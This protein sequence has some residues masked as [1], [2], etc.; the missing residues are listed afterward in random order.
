MRIA[1][2]AAPNTGPAIAE[3]EVFQRMALAAAKLGWTCCRTR[4]TREIEEFAPDVVLA[5]HFLVPKLTAYPTL[6]LMWNPPAYWKDHENLIKNVVSYDG[7]LFADP[8]TKEFVRDLISPLAVRFVEGRWFPTCHATSLSH[9]PRSGLAYLQTGWD[10]ERYRT[11]LPRLEQSVELHRYGP[12]TKMLPFDGSSVLD[13]LAGHAAALC[14][15]SER[16]R[17]AGVP[18]ARVFEAAAS[19]AII[20][21]DGNNFVSRT[22]GDAAL[23]VDP[24]AP[25][26][27]IV[28]QVARHLAWIENNPSEAAHMRRKAH[29]FFTEEFTFE[30]LLQQLPALVAE[31]KD[32]WRPP[33]AEEE[34]SV[35]FIVRT[36]GRELTFLDRA[37]ASLERQT[38]PR[39]DAI[40][41]AYRNADAVRQHLQSKPTGRLSVRVVEC[42][43]KGLRS[44]ALWAGLETVTSAFYGVLDDDDTLF[45]NHVAACLATLSDNP[46]IDL[47]YAGTMAVHEGG[48]VSEVRSIMSFCHF[49]A[50]VF[51]QRNDI[52]SNAWLARGSTL[53]RVGLDPQLDVGEDYYLLLRLCRGA[54]FA[55]TWRLTSEYR[56]RA[57]DATHSPLAAKLAD[58]QERIRRRLYLSVHAPFLMPGDTDVLNILI[59][60]DFIT[61]RIVR[62]AISRRYLRKGLE[63]YLKD[64]GRLPRRIARLPALLSQ[65]GIKHLIHHIEKRGA[66]E[67][68]RR[69][70]H[71][72]INSSP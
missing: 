62:A 2:H 32:A 3:A 28:D 11:I 33:V 58:S 52:F 68:A 69:L 20:I 67:Y 24:D 15:H 22:F 31:I 12:E 35:S 16:H 50:D 14:L 45:P 43:D 36:G 6:G 17:Q 56:Q 53:N 41:V 29:R 34:S 64:F 46:D 13:A 42:A 4:D 59:K 19:G 38:H 1:V 44:T 39:M 54:N 26:D 18:A 30:R 60:N 10:K 27:R 65:R 49:V 7:H 70:R 51:R 63:L 61:G 9:G 71:G 47:A 72:P 23:Y 25:P 5:E 21:S 55:P 57:H 8:G 40:I 37:L 66:E 48:E